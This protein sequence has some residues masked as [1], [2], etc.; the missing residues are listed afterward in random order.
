MNDT[1]TPIA[2]FLVTQFDFVCPECLPQDE[3]E[4]LTFY[5]KEE[6]VGYYNDLHIGF[7][8]RG[9]EN[10]GEGEDLVVSC[11]Y[12]RKTLAE[13]KVTHELSDMFVE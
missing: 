6:I 10:A 1:P 4:T 13:G 9:H 12:C 11:K 3:K 8:L 7:H 2:F 5:D